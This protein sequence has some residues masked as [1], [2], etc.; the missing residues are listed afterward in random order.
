MVVRIG[1]RAHRN[2]PPVNA[3]SRDERV[4]IRWTDEFIARLKVE[5]PRANDDFELAERLG[6]PPWCRG[7]LRAAL[8]WASLVLRPRQARQRHPCRPWP[9]LAGGVA[10]KVCAASSGDEQGLQWGRRPN[11]IRSPPGSD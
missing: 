11:A 3:P 6:L 8:R 7:A 10:R 4:K 5:A 9:D 2:P 1:E